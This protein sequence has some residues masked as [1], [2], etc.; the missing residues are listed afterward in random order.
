M[1]KKKYIVVQ[2][3]DPAEVDGYSDAQKTHYLSLGYL[4]CLLANGTTKWLT[5]SQRVIRAAQA[6]KPFFRFSS[7]AQIPK[8]NRHTH[9]RHRSNFRKFMLDNWQ[10]VSLLLGLV[11][12][13][14]ALLTYWN[15]IF[16]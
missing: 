5:E 11:A 7:K 12:V 10:F 8:K 1:S 9:R 14:W 15:A 3:L 4:P 2:V 6:N 13:L 16:G